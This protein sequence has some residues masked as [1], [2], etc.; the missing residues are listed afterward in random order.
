MVISAAKHK[1][2][3]YRA[4]TVKGAVASVID[5]IKKGESLIIDFVKD[6]NGNIVAWDKV[7]M[8]INQCKG[9]KT[10]TTRLDNQKMIVTRLD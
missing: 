3:K 9:S 5:E 6:C 10:F 2:D 7:R 1:H 8:S 4:F